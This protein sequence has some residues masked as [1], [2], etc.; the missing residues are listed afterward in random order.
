MQSPLPDKSPVA[1]AP[2]NPL[3]ILPDFEDGLQPPADDFLM[4]AAVGPS[5]LPEASD[6]APVVT[7]AALLANAL[8]LELAYYSNKYHEE[9]EGNPRDE[10]PRTFA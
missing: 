4:P 9:P 2:P 8:R 5:A 1:E 7:G 6:D 3:N 10:I